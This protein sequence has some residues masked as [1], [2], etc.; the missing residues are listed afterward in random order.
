MP[1]ATTHTL[2]YLV[3]ATGFSKRQIRF[4]IT[5]KLVPGA[6]ESR[7]PNAVYGEETLHR[8][9][10]IRSLK[11][12]RI[13]PTGRAMT[14]DEIAHALDALSPDGIDA[15]LSGRAEL[16]ILDTEAGTM[17]SLASMAESPAHMAAIREF[18]IDDFTAHKI[19]PSCQPDLPLFP[20][21]PT[22]LHHL[23]HQLQDLLT[24]LG[25]DTPLDT[26]TGHQQWRRITTPDVEL[27]VRQ[28]D[29]PQACARLQTMAA[30]LGRLLRPRPP[31]HTGG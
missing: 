7:G 12:Q 23:L 28:P 17:E 5:R 19:A 14:L 13:E 11:Q 22:D 20:D 8:L 16:A 31:A 4:Y 18:D 25:S 21:D 29:D 15:L 3:T 1:D 30:A 6:G 10:L 24:E 26:V 2:D 9:R 27:N